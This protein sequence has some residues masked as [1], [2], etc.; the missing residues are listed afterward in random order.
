MLKELAIRHAQLFCLATDVLLYGTP[1]EQL[2][3]EMSPRAS[4]SRRTSRGWPAKTRSAAGETRQAVEARTVRF[5]I[6]F[7]AEQRMNH[8]RTEEP[9][10]EVGTA[11]A[12]PGGRSGLGVA[13]PFRTHA[14][15]S[16][17]D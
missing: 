4:A 9:I 15:R 2:A 11:G 17:V 1:E 6:S 13:A 3:F 7:D 10:S 14:P 8:A 5:P 16:G 12:G